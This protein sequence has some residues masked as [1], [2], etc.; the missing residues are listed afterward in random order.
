VKSA[1]LV[2][3]LTLGCAAPATSDWDRLAHEARALR[4]AIPAG[5]GAILD[6]LDARARDRLTSLEHPSTR[7]RWEEAVPRLRR[8][9]AAS[10]GMEKLPPAEPRNIRSVGVLERDGIRI[11]KL[12]YETLPGIQVPAHLYGP[13]SPPAKVPAILLVPGHWYAES[14]TKADF[15][16]F[17]ITMARRGFAVLTYDPFGQGERGIS[18]RDHRRTELLAAGIAQEAIVAFE[19]LCAFQLLVGRPGIDPGRI[20]MTGASGGGFNSWIVP[21]LETRIAATVSV[22]G[23]SE[24]LEQLRAVRSVDWFTAKEHCHYIPGLFRYADNHELLAC[25]APRPVMVISAHNDIGF[26]VP[27][28]RDVVKYGERLYSMLGAPGQVGYFEDA[29][30]GHGYQKRKREAA[31]GWFLK[32]LKQEGDGSPAAEPPLALSAWDAPELRCFP[33]GENH[34]AGPGLVA[35]AK[36][37]AG[38][39]PDPKGEDDDW[40]GS[41]LGLQPQALPTAPDLIREDP[42]LSFCPLAETSASGPIRV[43]WRM[44]DGVV[45]PG[46]LLR[47]GPPAKGALLGVADEGKESLLEHPA[48]KEAYQAGWVVLL[49]DLRGMGELTV[50]KP[51]WVCATSLLLGE[52]FVGRQAQDLIAGVR[53]LRAEPSLRGKPVGVLARGAF[54]AFAGLYASRMEPGIP[55]VAAERGFSSFRVFVDRPRSESASFT[56]AAPDRERDVVLDREIPHALVPFGVLG[57]AKELSAL[58]E[59]RKRVVW[60]AAVDGDYQPAPGPQSVMPFLRA[61]LEEAR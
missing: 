37:V 13:L 40:L 16:A 14:K 15:Q 45:V 30:E 43:A 20:G 50:T 49:A 55:W 38:A 23:T 27:G 35:L 39:G 1:G 26:P 52:N 11:E 41:L 17:A 2:L 7:A 5:D 22:V 6:G 32:W 24:F 53:A 31:Y 33:P 46:I 3:L 18:V 42:R 12:V 10:L 25:V 60:A 34:S 57:R 54:A 61:R 59:D 36:T 21:A 4:P 8:A 29:Q 9:L 48:V 58:M 44:P 19:S 51:G 28:Q 56:L 47:S